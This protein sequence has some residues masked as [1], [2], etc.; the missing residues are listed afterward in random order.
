MRIKSIG[1]N[2]E[3]LPVVCDFSQLYETQHA[4]VVRVRTTFVQFSH[5][6][7]R[8]V[9]WDTCDNSNNGLRERLPEIC[10]FR[11]CLL[12]LLL[13]KL[14]FHTRETLVFVYK[15]QYVNFSF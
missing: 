7:V 10:V 2:G 13:R 3:F 1:Q 12:G 6:V 4:I 15:A 11:Y 5:S 14:C 8:E 9:K